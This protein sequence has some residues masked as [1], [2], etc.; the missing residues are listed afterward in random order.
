MDF[1]IV[2][3]YPLTGDT[4]AIQKLAQGIGDGD[5][6]ALGVTRCGKTFTVPNYKKLQR[7]HLSTQIIIRH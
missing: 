4:P 7:L 5:P 2:S 6:K 1:Q 3:D